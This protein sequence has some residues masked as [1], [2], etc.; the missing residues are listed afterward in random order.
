[1]NTVYEWEN[2]GFLEG[3]NSAIE[4]QQRISLLE[5]TV[6]YIRKHAVEEWI[7]GILIPLVI[8][9]S[10][11]NKNVYIDLDKLINLMKKH[12]HMIGQFGEMYS[13][14]SSIDEDAEFACF[15]CEKYLY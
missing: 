6:N 10:N 1:M 15:I 13:H 3:C 7:C 4:K 11:T 12:G 2:L 9:I 8:R 14:Y 5:R